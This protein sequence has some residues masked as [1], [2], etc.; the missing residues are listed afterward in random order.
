[1]E[2]IELLVKIATILEKL[3]INYCVTGGYAISVWGRPRSTFDIDVVIQLKEEDIIPLAKHL[4]LLSR[5]GY[6]EESS[7]AKAVAQ[8]GEFNFIHSESGIKVDFW[9]IQKDNEI[10]MNELKRKID[11]II[12]GQKIYFISP[13]DLILSKLRWYQ[14]SQST[15]HLEDI[16]SIL[17]ISGNQ[18]NMQYLKRWTKKQ[19]AEHILAKILKSL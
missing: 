8:G 6:I 10:G 16:E 2:F 12:N 3:N 14:K 13:E 18:M 11:K 19:N 7:A 5:A 15:R 9:V 4:R 1:M 17:R